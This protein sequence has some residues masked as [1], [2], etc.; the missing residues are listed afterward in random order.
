VTE[1]PVDAYGRLSYRDSE[2]PPQ[3]AR[4][5]YWRGRLTHP[6]AVATTSPHKCIGGWVAS[7]EWWLHCGH[8]QTP[9]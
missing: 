3:D 7:G 1:R 8:C 2:I 6:D 5:A 9:A 4:Y